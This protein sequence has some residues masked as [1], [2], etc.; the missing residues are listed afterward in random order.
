MRLILETWRYICHICLRFRRI[1]ICLC[2]ITI[3]DE[4]I[5][6]PFIV[7]GLLNCLF[8]SLIS[9]ATTKHQRSTVLTLCEGHYRWIISKRAS[10]AG[11]V[12]MQCR[13]RVPD[14]KFHGANQGPTWVLS[15]PGGTH[16]GPWTLPSVVYICQSKAIRTHDS[17]VRVGYHSAHSVGG[18]RREVSNWPHGICLYLTWGGIRNKVANPGSHGVTMTWKHFP[19]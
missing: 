5:H 15:A 17:S 12:S 1:L 14:S 16:I 7:A 18:I 10:N 8:K 19:H 6:D 3:P 4:F 13:H 2:D 11:N 9:L